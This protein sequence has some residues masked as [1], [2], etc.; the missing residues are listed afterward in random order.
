MRFG[1]AALF[2]ALLHPVAIFLPLLE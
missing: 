1:L 2:D